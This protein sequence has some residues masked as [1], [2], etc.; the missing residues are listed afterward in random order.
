M[1]QSR[2][3]NQFWR[4]RGRLKS[5]S[6]ETGEI[7]QGMEPWGK[8]PEVSSGTFTRRQPAKIEQTGTT[9][10]TAVNCEVCIALQFLVVTICKGGI[11]PSTYH[12]VEIFSCHMIMQEWTTGE[13]I[14]KK[15]SRRW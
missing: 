12:L 8:E 9:V 5:R 10:H 11:K 13:V 6:V 1:S 7:E 4:T 14:C 3:V 2:A 15:Y